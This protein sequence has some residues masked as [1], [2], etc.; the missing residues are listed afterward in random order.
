VVGERLT[1]SALL[2]IF[3]LFGGLALLAV[4]PRRV[5]AA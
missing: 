2:G 4:T 1:H 5:A 3:L